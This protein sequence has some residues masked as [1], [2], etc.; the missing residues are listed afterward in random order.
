MEA[1]TMSDQTSDQRGRV[2]LDKQMHEIERL[3]AEMA[4][5]PRQQRT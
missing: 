3:R 2:N 4:A 5:A 1:I